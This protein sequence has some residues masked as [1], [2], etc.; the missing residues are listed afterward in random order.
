MS[1][2]SEIQPTDRQLVIDLVRQ[3]GVDVSTWANGKGGTA[4]AAVNPK[5]C[6]DWSFVEPG[7]VVVLNLWHREI[8]ETGG[9][10]TRTA[11]LREIAHRETIPPRKRRAESMDQAILTAYTAGLPVRVIVLEGSIRK[12]GD[13]NAKTSRAS[14]RLLDPVAWAVTDYDI[15]T[16]RCTLTR[17]VQPISPD[18]QFGDEVI[19]GFEGAARTRFVRHRQR[20]RDL[21]NKKIAQAL[22][23]N[24]GR[25]ICEVPNCGFDYADRYGDIG[26]HYAQVH[27]KEP[28]SEAPEEGRRVTLD[29]L[30]VVCANCHVMIHIGGACRPLEGLIPLK[31]AA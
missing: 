2:L 29:D 3:A 7:K 25:L 6:Y 14:K 31:A 24:H 9:T 22:R 12:V 21:R 28:L 30:A 20:E 19:D 17:G 15:A 10:L 8:D 1:I 27:H 26:K 5:Y 11:N 18:H 23:N 4:K 16:G 13:P